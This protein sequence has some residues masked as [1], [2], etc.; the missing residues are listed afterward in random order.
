MLNNSTCLMLGVVETDPILILVWLFTFP[1]SLVFTIVWE[2][3][4]SIYNSN[5]AIYITNDGKLLLQCNK[6]Y[7]LLSP[8]DIEKIYFEWYSGNYQPLNRDVAFRL[9]DG[10]RCVYRMVENF[11]LL[12]RWATEHGVDFSFVKYPERYL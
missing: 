6:K 8:S 2:I 7:F 3:W 9:K 5:N 1:L 10:R 11:H 4:K 12:Q